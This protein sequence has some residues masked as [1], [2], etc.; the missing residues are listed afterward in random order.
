MKNLIKYSNLLLI[1]IILLMSFSCT[2]W[3]D[4]EPENKLVKQEF[5]QKKEDVAAVMAAMYD[6]YRENCEKVWVFGEVRADMV[7]FMSTYSNGNYQLIGKSEIL[8][9][10]SS[11]DWG[12]FYDAINLANTILIFADDVLP[13]DETFDLKTEKAYEA[14]ALFIRAK[15]YYDLVRIWK[16]VPLVLVASSSD[17]VSFSIPKNSEAEIIKQIESDLLKAKTMAFTDEYASVPEM[18]K[19]RANVYSINALL[20]DIYLWSEQYEKCIAICDEIINSGKFQLQPANDWFLLY[21]PGNATESIFEIQYNDLYEN[22]ESPFNASIMPAVGL[23]KITLK[24]KAQE[25]FSLLDIRKGSPDPRCKYQ[26]TSLTPS[27]Y[28]TTAQRD[29]HLIFFRYADILLNKA[30][31]LAELGNFTESNNYIN[32]ILSRATLSPAYFEPDIL[33][34]RTVIL[35]QRA[36]EFA[37]EGK[38]WFDILRFAKRNHFE[39][40]QLIINLILEGA[41]VKQRPVLRSRILDT[42]SYY[43]PISQS[44]VDHN[45]NL[46]QN[47]YYDR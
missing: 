38:R 24:P 31:A 8:P 29:A 9:T 10:N 18:F 2:K 32:E 4:L 7:E 27:T 42:M 13:L 12:S 26:C 19:G 46:K 36:K 34:F 47:P 5:W 43:L 17:T 44:E 14:E 3:L 45:P 22:E 33:T 40:K 35:E 39:N 25:L 11:I 6:Q 37:L 23:V 16:E 20:S 1:I 15:C 41:D 30:E 21:Y 28:R